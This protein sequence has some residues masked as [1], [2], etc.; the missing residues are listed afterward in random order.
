MAAADVIDHYISALP[1]ETRRLAHGEWGI[2]VEP[3]QARGWALHVGL[4]LADGVLTAQAFAL[5]A[6]Q[7]LN[8]WTLLHWNRGTRYVRFACTSAG[9]IWVHGDLPAAAV[10][11][12]AL[13]RL[14]GLLVEAAIAVREYAAAKEAG[15]QEP[16]GGGWL[17]PA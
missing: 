10:D 5:P 12:R 13:D 16:A 17:P 15:P 11:E 2:T 9:D 1:G 14:L 7:D 4:R 6:R 8:A 3:E